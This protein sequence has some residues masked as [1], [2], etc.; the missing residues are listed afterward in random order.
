MFFILPKNLLLSLRFSDFCTPLFFAFLA[1]AN[2]IE[3]ID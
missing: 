1:I 3:E 2:L